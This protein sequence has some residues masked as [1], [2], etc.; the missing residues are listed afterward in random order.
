MR[1]EVPVPERDAADEAE[2]FLRSLRR[3]DLIYADPVYIDHEMA[4]GDWVAVSTFGAADELTGAND[5]PEIAPIRLRVGCDDDGREAEAYLSIRDA[6]A[7]IKALRAAIKKAKT[8]P[9]ELHNHH[10]GTP[11]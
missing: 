3:P 2:R 8:F 10:E 6:E 9:Q 1:W 5:V 7:V 4:M 11:Q